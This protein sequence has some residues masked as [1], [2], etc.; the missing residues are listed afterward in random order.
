MGR[1]PVRLAAAGR[2]LDTWAATPPESVAMARREAAA[3]LAAV[4]K[5]MAAGDWTALEAYGDINGALR[6]MGVLA[7]ACA[8]GRRS[9]AAITTGRTWRS[10]RVPEWIPTG[11]ADEAA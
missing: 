8:G 9:R 7:A 4:R 11:R 2:V 6:R 1:D 5:A 10:T 3:E